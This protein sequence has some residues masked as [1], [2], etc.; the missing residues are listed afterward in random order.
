[1]FPM[2]AATQRMVRGYLVRLY[3]SHNGGAT[4]N[5]KVK[6]IYGLY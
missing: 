2:R 1:M 6:V 4:E 3:G 5:R